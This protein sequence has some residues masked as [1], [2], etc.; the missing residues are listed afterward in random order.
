MPLS[1]AFVVTADS[2]GADLDAVP[3]AH[4]LTDK[5]ALSPILSL[6]HIS[7]PTRPYYTSYADCT[8]KKKKT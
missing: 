5:R 3:R 8:L 2:V 6:T 1:A 4:G 7:E